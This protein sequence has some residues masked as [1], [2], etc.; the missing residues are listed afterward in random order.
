M[1][2][3]CHQVWSNDVRSAAVPHLS[4]GD[5]LLYT[6]IRQGFDV[7]T[8]LDGFSFAGIDPAD[9]SVEHTSPLPGTAV[10]DTLQ[11]SGLVTDTGDFWQGTVTGILRIR[12]E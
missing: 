11:M 5:G 3:G 7:T 1:P 6:V 9:G 10:N 2:I 4:T 8:P 12:G